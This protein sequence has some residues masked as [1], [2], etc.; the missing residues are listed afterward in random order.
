[1]YKIILNLLIIFII[2]N[3]NYINANDSININNLKKIP[4]LNEGRIKPLDTFAKKN[5]LK[6]NKNYEYKNLDSIYWL[7]ELIFIPNKAYEKEIFKINKNLIKILNLKKKNYFSF[8]ELFEALNQKTKQ[9]NK[10]YKLNYYNLSKSQ[11]K[12]LNLHKKILNYLNISQSLSMINYKFDLNKE[13]IEKLNLKKKSKFC[14]LDI[15]KKKEILLNNI[16]IIS[17]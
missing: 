4:I 10:L 17:K 2:Y 5:F 12:L 8:N 13:L 11:K 14:Y 3:I 15:L 6:I 9:I 1:M 16:K 7:S